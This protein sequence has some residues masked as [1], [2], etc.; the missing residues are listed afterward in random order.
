MD[1]ESTTVL[2]DGDDQATAPGSNEQLEPDSGSVSADPRHDAPPDD[3]EPVDTQVPRPVRKC[4]K[5][6]I[7]LQAVQAPAWQVVAPA[8][9]VVYETDSIPSNEVIGADN[10]P[11]NVTLDIREAVSIDSSVDLEPDTVAPEEAA[12]VGKWCATT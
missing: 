10:T 1:N 9:P 12:V 6:R 3:A 8:V 11:N 4:R 5:P 7:H 2:A